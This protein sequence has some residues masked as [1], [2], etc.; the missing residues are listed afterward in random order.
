MWGRD[1]LCSLFT[2]ALQGSLDVKIQTLL[3]NHLPSAYPSLESPCL[4]SQEANK[5]AG[6]K[7]VICLQREKNWCRFYDGNVPTRREM[8]QPEEKI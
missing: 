2:V 4:M 7:H 8:S 3:G 6:I 5:L 1:G